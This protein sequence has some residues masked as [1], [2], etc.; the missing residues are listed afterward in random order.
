[1]KSRKPILYLA[2]LFAI[3]CLYQ[4]SFTWK[5]SGIEDDAAEYAFKQIDENLS[6]DLVRV[7]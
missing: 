5:V 3:V 1:M 6:T 2:I 4:L 7:D